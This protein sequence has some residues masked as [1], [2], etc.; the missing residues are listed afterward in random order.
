MHYAECD[1]L[2]PDANTTVTYF[3]VEQAFAKALDDWLYAASK[4]AKLG[5]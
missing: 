2:V 1:N 4:V 3:S 5:K